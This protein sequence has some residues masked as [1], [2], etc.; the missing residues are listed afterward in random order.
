MFYPLCKSQTSPTYALDNFIFARNGYVW[1]K[2]DKVS[3]QEDYQN[4]VK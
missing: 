1:V 4:I 2:Y 3:V